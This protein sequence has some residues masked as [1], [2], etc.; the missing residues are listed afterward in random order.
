MITQWLETY[1]GQLGRTP[2]SV[3]HFMAAAQTRV[4]ELH[5]DID[6]SFGPPELAEQIDTWKDIY[7]IEERYRAKLCSQGAKAW[8]VEVLDEWRW[9]QESAGRE[10]RAPEAHLQAVARHTEVSPYTNENFLKWGFL[11]ACKAV[12]I[13]DAEVNAAPVEESHRR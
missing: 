11:Q 2:F 1:R 13:F 10:G 12:G 7:G 5:P 4:A 9:H 3:Q 6:L 8:I